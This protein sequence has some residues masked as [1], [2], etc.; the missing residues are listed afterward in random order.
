[1]PQVKGRIFLRESSGAGSAVTVFV[2]LIDTGKMDIRS[3]KIAEMVYESNL[4]ELEK[5]GL[6]FVLNIDDIDVSKRVEISVLADVDGDGKAG[7]G[8]YISKQA[9]PVL[10]KG[11]PD[12]VEVE[13]LVI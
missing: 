12:Y 4:Q 1:M 5:N 6:P 2:R 13:V 9:Y 11:Y 7:K 10:T 3:V 8:D